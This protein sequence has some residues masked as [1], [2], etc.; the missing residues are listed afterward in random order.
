M[1]KTRVLAA[2]AAVVVVLA[3]FS[4]L[5]R[6][7]AILTALGLNDAMT[8]AEYIETLDML[9]D[10]IYTLQAKTDMIDADDTEGAKAHIEELKAPFNSF[11]AI[12]NPPGDFADGHAKIQSGCQAIVEYL[13]L[14]KDIVGETDEDKLASAAERMTDKLSFAME[15][16]REGTGMVEEAIG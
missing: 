16:L 14:V 13:D 9:S 12:D 7:D 1:K 10:E 2:A 15:Q 11:A 4:V 5:G 8:E 3:V 6:G